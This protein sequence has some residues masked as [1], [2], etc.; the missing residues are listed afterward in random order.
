MKLVVPKGK[1][2]S[3]VLF[4]YSKVLNIK[5]K[6]LFIRSKLL[7]LLYVRGKRT[8]C[9]TRQGFSKKDAWF[10]PCGGGVAG[11]GKGG[12]RWGMLSLAPSAA[13]VSPPVGGGGYW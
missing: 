5:T 9:L 11:A 4:I 13:V 6:V 7:F 10:V 3:E 1:V 8:L 12:G 2:Y